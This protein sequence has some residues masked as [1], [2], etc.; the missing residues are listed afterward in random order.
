MRKLLLITFL[1]A[2][3]LFAQVPQVPDTVQLKD[4]RTNFN[5]SLVWL[6]TNKGTRTNG[7][8][9]PVAACT[10]GDSYTQTVSRHLWWCFGGATPWAD[11]GYIG[12]ASSAWGQITGLLT[13]QTDLVAA[14][15]LKTNL[16]DFNSH[17]GNTS[18]PHSTTKSQVG[19]GSVANGLQ[20]QASLNLSDLGS[21]VTARANLGLGGAAVLNIGAIAGT[22]AS[23]DHTHTGLYS[24]FSHVHNATD[25]TSGVFNH[26]R[27]GSSGL[28]TGT[29]VLYDDGV[30]RVP[31]G[32]SGGEANTTTNGGTGGIGLVLPKVGIDLPFKSLYAASAKLSLTDDTVNKRIAV[33]VVP[34]SIDHQTLSGA[35]ANTH[36]QIDTH[37]GATNNPHATTASQVGAVPLTRTVNSRALSADIIITKADVALGNVNNVVQE[38]ALGNPALDAYILSSTAAGVRSWIAQLTWTTLTGKP[39]TF[40]P[41][42]HAASHGV[43]QADAVTVAQSQVTNLAADLALKAALASPALTG[44]P[45]APT[46]TPGTNTTQLATTAY[47]DAAMATRVP[48]TRTVAGK[49]LSSDVPLVKG[50]VGLGNVDNTT[51]ANKPVSTAAQSALD[52][53]ANLASP[54]LTGTPT[55]PTAAP[56]TNTTQ[57]ASTAFVKALGD[58]KAASNAGTT[59][60]GV[61][62]TLGSTCTITASGIV[63]QTTGLASALPA[64]CTA[65][66]TSA[67][68]VYY[69]TDTTDWYLCGATNTWLRM[70]STLPGAA[71]S[72]SGTEQSALATPSAGA[73]A[74]WFDSTEHDLNCK[75]NNSAT[76]YRM[77]SLSTTV[78][79][80]LANLSSD[81]QTQLNAKAAAAD[82]TTHTSNTS[83]PHSVTK[84]QVSLGSVTDDVQTKAAVVPNTAP[85]AGQVLVGNAGGTAYAPV[86]VSGDGTLSSAGALAVTKINGKTLTLPYGCAVGDPAGSALATGV[87]CYI[88]IPTAGTITGWDIIVDAGTATVDVWKIATGTAKPTV[89]NTITAIAK[90]AIASGTAIHST[91]LTGWTTSV[92]AND[93][94]GFNLDA[95]ATA[96]YITINLQIAH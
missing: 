62:C 87:L 6:D 40:A 45:T 32:S 23:G 33:D 12:G 37:L 69:A 15:N 74:C 66:S 58:T 17:T 26:A 48:T 35:G 43:G 94:I 41:S 21:T 96:K 63:S 39:T 85:S 64:T 24:L 83:N 25:V 38:P 60:N 75:L 68:Q 56:G 2:A 95:V 82:L 18:N 16:T 13:D 54:T 92:A 80:Y 10:V 3:Q 86:S 46:A 65:A 44:A 81:V 79:G 76:V 93:I 50:D 34:G 84:A 57:I 5:T 91:T 29:L 19:L 89:A 31:P 4:T 14:L 1:A 77:T 9:D 90:P 42:A 70:L 73:G 36:A 47:T 27:L 49:P 71:F 72:M 88:P 30:F 78:L 53:K 22:A 7:T 52:L 59:V 11:I 28:G 51:D 20:L 8:T 61:P 67:L 55:A